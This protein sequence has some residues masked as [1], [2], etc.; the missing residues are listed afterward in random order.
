[1]S[2]ELHLAVSPGEVW[3]A[4]IEDGAAVE[5]RIARSGAVR[6]GAVFLGRVD[7]LNRELRAAFVDIGQGPPAVLNAADALATLTEGR[8][9][10]VQVTKEARARKGPEVTTRLSLDG[11]LTDLAPGDATSGAPRRLDADAGPVAEI[12]DAYRAVPPDRIVID[13]RA[14]FAAARAYLARTHRALAERVEFGAVDL[15]AR[16][17]VAASLGPEVALPGGGRIVIEASEAAILIDVDSGGAPA[18]T[19]NLAAARMIARHIRLRNL[20]GPIVIDFIGMKGRED[21]ARVAAALKD[22][23]SAD[24]A[25]P[26]ALGWTRLGHFEL[27]RKR[28]HPSLDDILTERGPGG[29][30]VKTA[31]TVALEA[32]RQLAR[33]ARAEPARAFALRA[34]PEV[35]AALADGPARPARRELETRLARALAVEPEA[36]F[37]RETF[38]IRP[39]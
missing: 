33:A 16:D 34:A 37:G 18:L 35:A 1:M 9:I 31:L 38:D 10:V 28:R 21:R 14:A 24:P 32:L 3:A 23:L 29:G 12:L 8:A 7:T 27:V 36:K 39:L 25:G 11:A 5:L 13:D 4:L 19:T 26:E 17:D 15:F 20:A 2:T 30:R 22:A 6:V